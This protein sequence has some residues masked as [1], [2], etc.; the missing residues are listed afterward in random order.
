MSILV[1]LETFDSSIILDI[2]YATANNFLNQPVYS[3]HKCFLRPDVAKRLSDVQKNMQAR[4]YCIKV[5]DGYRPLSVQK[6]FW[7]LC[8]NKNYVAD[9]SIGSKHNRGAAID[10]TLVDRRGFELPMPSSFDEFSE[11][12][13]RNYFDCSAEKVQNRQLLEDA[14]VD[15]GFEPLPHEWWHFNDPAWESY[16]ILDISFEE[17]M[18]HER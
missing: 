6:K 10:L 5:F 13:H 18:K 2:R 3:H 8:P 16:D 12:A 9:P 1:D 4:G 17:L 14:M 11:K 7:D 15:Q